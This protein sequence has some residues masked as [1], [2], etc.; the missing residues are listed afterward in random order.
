MFDD[1][2]HAVELEGQHGAGRAAYYTPAYVYE[3][4]LDEIARVTGP[5]WL[6]DGSVLEPSYGDGRILGAVVGRWGN[7]QPENLHGTDIDKGARDRTVQRLR[8]LLRRPNDQFSNIKVANGLIPSVPT[9]LET[10]RHRL[11]IGNPPYMSMGACV[12]KQ[13]EGVVATTRFALRRL[14]VEGGLNPPEESSLGVDL[15]MNSAYFFVIQGLFRL[16]ENGI[17]AMVVPAS[18]WVN[19]NTAWLRRCMQ[20]RTTIVAVWSFTGH[21]LWRTVTQA[22]TAIV[23]RKTRPPLWSH[24]IHVV[25]MNRLSN[26]FAFSTFVSQDQNDTA[27]FDRIVHGANPFC[28]AVQERSVPLQALMRPRGRLPYARPGQGVGQGRLILALSKHP[29]L[30]GDAVGARV[31][32]DH[33]QV[34]NRRLSHILEAGDPRTAHANATVFMVAACLNSSLMTYYRRSVCDGT[35]EDRNLNAN[36]VLQLPLPRILTEADAQ[37]R[38]AE[39]WQVTTR[40]NHGLLGYATDP[41]IEILGRVLCASVFLYAPGA[42]QE[43]AQV[44]ELLDTLVC[45]LYGVHDGTHGAV[46]GMVNEACALHQQPGYQSRITPDAQGWAG[47]DAMWPVGDI[48]AD[49]GMRIPLDEGE[50]GRYL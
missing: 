37:R 24:R 4:L 31:Y 25:T 33:A 22:I 35:I 8:V 26:D 6:A 5:D 28:H 1:R 42:A 21:T 10:P 7:I 11:I 40:G 48:W 29:L 30:T 15:Q 19:D 32:D 27:M 9:L 46:Q 23:V 2:Q 43:S 36:R 50:D 14:L 34:E 12:K 13:S 16:E 44:A 39:W 49:G 20:C 41:E 3:G 18:L 45:R 47:W 17:L 38:L